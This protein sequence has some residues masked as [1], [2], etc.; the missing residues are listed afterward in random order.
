MALESHD[1]DDERA[2]APDPQPAEE[3]T[4]PFD[5][6]AEADDADAPLAD[7]PPDDAPIEPVEPFAHDEPVEP[8]IDE[9]AT[10]VH[11]TPPGEVEGSAVEEPPLHPL[12][13]LAPT[14]ALARLDPDAPDFAPLRAPDFPVVWR[15]YDVQAVDAYVADVTAAVELFEQRTTPTIAVQRALERVGEQ[16]A[17]ILQQ[18]QSA[19]DETT[20]ESRAAADD[21]VQA[22]AREARELHDEAVAR[23]RALDDDVERLWEERQRLIEATKE[24]ADRLRAVAEEGE[25]RF[26]P[27]AAPPPAADEPP[28][29]PAPPPP[30]APPAAP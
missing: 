15:G 6:L 1:R 22:A 29:P 30:D 9:P 8:A 20:R 27:A 25:A 18:A 13:E 4:A 26:P 12:D 23:V 28:A 7:A 19:A 2:D 21:R 5:A 24:L 3:T 17:A 10:A 14:Q 16:T 11:E